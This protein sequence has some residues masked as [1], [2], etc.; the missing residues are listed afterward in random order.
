MIRPS[1]GPAT[2]SLLVQIQPVESGHIPSSPKQCSSTR[3]VATIRSI[4]RREAPGPQ[5]HDVCRGIAFSSGRPCC[6]NCSI[7]LE[8]SRDITKNR[9]PLA[10][11][12][13]TSEAFLLMSCLIASRYILLSRLNKKLFAFAIERQWPT[14]ISRRVRWTPIFGPLKGRYLLKLPCVSSSVLSP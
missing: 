6:N 14:E 4:S 13:F 7:T 11:L 8:S 2:G 9:R 1:V 3:M 12:F 10:I 5:R